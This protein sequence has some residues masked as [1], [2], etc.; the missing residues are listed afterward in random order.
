[1]NIEGIGDI[2]AFKAWIE[3]RI[4]TAQSDAI[5]R[6]YPVGSVITSFNT[7]NP[8]TYLGI[9]TWALESVGKVLMGAGA[10]EEVGTSVGSDSVTLSEGQLPSHVHSLG[11]SK[12]FSGS[13]GSAGSHGHTITALGPGNVGNW[14]AS[15]VHAASKSAGD[16]GY[17]GFLGRQSENNGGWKWY[18]RP[19]DT[20]I[21]SNLR[22]KDWFKSSDAST[23]SHSFSGSISLSGNTGSAGSGQ[24]VSVVQASLKLFIWR[25]TA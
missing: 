8:A 7:A 15:N 23:H 24:P 19:G 6:I 1:M 2:D 14:W 17:P 22:D 20:S 5:A 12:S 25:R 10:A 21:A 11:G 18:S 4:E 9:G 3:Q 13:T 16:C